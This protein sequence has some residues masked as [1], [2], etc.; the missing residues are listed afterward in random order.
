MKG[1]MHGTAAHRCWKEKI[2]ARCTLRTT[3]PR[4][5]TTS[6]RGGSHHTTPTMSVLICDM[7]CIRVASEGYSVSIAHRPVFVLLLHRQVFKENRFKSCQKSSPWALPCAMRAET[8]NDIMTRM[9]LGALIRVSQ[10]QHRSSRRPMASIEMK[11]D[12]A[13]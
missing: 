7:I 10:Q 6:S 4:D 1:E 2:D 9:E 11:M 5:D 13:V 8:Q 12:N 3:A